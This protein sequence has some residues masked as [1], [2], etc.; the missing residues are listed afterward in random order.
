[1]TDVE[2]GGLTDLGTIALEK[3][4]TLQGRFVDEQGAAVQVSFQ[5]GLLP[6]GSRTIEW[7]QDYGYSSDATGSFTV[8]KLGHKQYV[9]R[10][11][12]HDAAYDGEKTASASVSGNVMLDAHSGSLQGRVIRLKTGSLLVLRVKSATAERLR[13]RVLDD[14]GFA[15]A[16][17]RFYGPGPRPLRLPPGAYRVALLDAQDNVLSESAVS[18]GAATMELELVR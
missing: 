3:E 12:N 5:L 15:L 1:M 2:P 4:V 14:Q 17:D 13:F 18:V 10:T 16:W 7:D 6:P 11:I 8:K 9:L